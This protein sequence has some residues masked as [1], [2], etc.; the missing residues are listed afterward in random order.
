M[1][2]RREHFY[3]VE[4]RLA[5]VR[6]FK[7]Q[8]TLKLT[9]ASGSPSRWNLILGENGCGKTTILQCLVRM[10]PIAAFQRK[11]TGV[12][13]SG[14]PTFVDP[15][16]AEHSNDEITG[17]IRNRASESAS[18][19]AILS[20]VKFNQKVTSEARF[21]IGANI[22]HSNGE[23][24]DVSILQAKHTLSKPDP[25]VIAY[26]AGRH[27]GHSNIVS[28][29]DRDQNQTLFDEGLDLYD[30]S[31]VLDRLHHAMV[32]EK[33][34]AQT[35]AAQQVDA[36]RFNILIAAVAALLPDTKPEDVDVRGPDVPNRSKTQHGIHVRTK[37]GFVALNSLSVG[38]QTMFA[39]TVDL[40]W[41]LFIAYPASANPLAEPAVVL[42][43]EIDLHLHPMWQRSL[44]AHL[45]EHFPNVQFI[46]TTHSPV[47]AQE[48]IAAGANVSVV[49]WN[50]DEA[51]I[52]NNPLPQNEWRVDQVLVSDLFDFNS[53]RSPA[54]EV[55]LE[56]RKRLISKARLT[57]AEKIE[58]KGLDEFAL[59]LPTELSPEEQRVRDALRVLATNALKS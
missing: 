31:E 34:R 55:K 14:A 54:A 44:R 42:I 3:Y 28:I 2:Q 53:A 15:E 39:W 33:A 56:R 43:D 5:N 8:Q 25:L 20:N 19:D 4:L 35:E 18:I 49:R 13:Y 46:A 26:A 9:D 21:K 58:L 16:L 38:Y 1:T 51:V 32:D 41:R 12:N 30:A 47:T 36:K 48:S 45:L 6:A 59:A 11:K 7:S 27:V 37:S 23:L 52:I 22:E 17:F 24:T 29:Q 40:A 50:D 10:R 57:A